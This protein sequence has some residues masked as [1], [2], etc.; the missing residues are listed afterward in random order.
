MKFFKITVKRSKGKSIRIA[1]WLVQN[2]WVSE[3]RGKTHEWDPTIVNGFVMVQ[4]FGARNFLFTGWR[5]YI[6]LC[7]PW[8]IN[9]AIIN[10]TSNPHAFWAECWLPSSSL[11]AGRPC[12]PEPGQIETWSKCLQYTVK[13]SP[14]SIDQHTLTLAS[15]HELLTENTIRSLWPIYISIYLYMGF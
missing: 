3:V 1:K 12:N 2:R 4:N 7:R 14:V 15:S 6:H 8:L 9:D 11:P 10:L 5:E 13:I